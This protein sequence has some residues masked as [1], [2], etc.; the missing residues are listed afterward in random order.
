MSELKHYGTPRRSGRYPWGSG[1][2]PYQR[3]SDFLSIYNEYRRQGLSE[4]EIA[5]KMDI[6][7]SQLR[8][9]KT[10]SNNAVRAGDV[11]RAIR[12]KDKG[13]SNTEIGR[14][15]NKNES[16]I[17][18]LLD[19]TLQARSNEV[20]NM[21]NLLK[22]SIKEN[23][24]IDVGLGVERHLDISRTKL[25]TSIEMLKEE[26]YEIYYLK[27]DQA[28]TGKP[29]SLM[30]LA[31]P[32]IKWEEVNANK[33]NL[34][35]P[36][37]NIPKEV[38]EK[39]KAS[40]DLGPI[41]DISSNRV[42]IRYREDGGIDKDGL[43][44]LRR[45]VDDLSLGNSNYAQV[46][47]SVDGTHFLKGMSVYSDK[48]PEGYDIV[49]NTNKYKNTPKEEVFKKLK[50]DPDYPFGA[51]ITKRS[52]ALNIVNEEGA[53]GEWSKTL[54]SQ[55][56]SKQNKTLAK[57]QLDLAFKIKQEEYD[58]I[59]SLTN[60]TVKQ[61][62]LKSFADDCDASAVHLKAAA[63]PRQ[64]WHAIL[65]FPEMK[66]NEIYAPN[67]RN[68]ERVVLIR[69]PHGGTFE[70]P[71]LTVNNKQSIVKKVLGMAKDAVGINPKVA[72]QL[73]GAD[74]DGDT[75]LVIPTRGN[76]IKTS[77]PLKGLQNF[78][79]KESYAAYEGMPKMKPVTK[80]KEMGII[81]NLIT[82]M[83]IQGATPSELARAVRHSMVI[84][85]AEKHNLNYRQSAKD[86]GI[87]ALKA[88]YQSK[89]GK[90]GGASTLLSRAK[91]TLR[92]DPRKDKYRID[93]KTG[94]KIWV[95]EEEE[96]YIN[97]KGKLVKKT[98]STTQM[99]E[100]ENAFTLSSGTN[101]EAIYATY[102]NKLKALG[103][104]SRKDYINTKGLEY[105]PSARKTYSKEVSSLDAKLN[106]ALKNA[107]LERK[108]Q[109]IADAKVK[110]SRAA[111]PEMD[112][113]TL[114]KIK[115]QAI[116]SARKQV[117]AKKVT[118]DIS[119]I[120][121]EAIQ[122]GAISNNKLSKILDNTNN[123]LIKQLAT[124]RSSSSLSSAK[125]ARAKAMVTS[126]YTQAEIADAIGV[127]VSTLSKAINE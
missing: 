12:L 122:A 6:N 46:R 114:K 97:K 54:S 103:N 72:E 60:P 4:V 43:I 11:A 26:G 87:D 93:P 88:K 105:S 111:D 2:D 36:L 55:I 112:R 117:G 58:E 116:S 5:K 119:P 95:Q 8:A 42:F 107:P 22:D 15:M 28:G 73:S 99:Y 63:L 83:T 31:A 39:N 80:Q 1:E 90:V 96:S 115:G 106:L 13:Y 102:A 21:A 32:G 24:Y 69:H 104:Q 94:K 3:G 66:E 40:L 65:P 78:D 29:T 127:P 109:L 56:L 120:E 35:M 18:A 47:I 110:A 51:T 59:M 86:N 30:A 34:N 7:T 14:L 71:E 20:S 118:V 126:G 74:F 70:I 61:K 79:P 101:I 16:S 27:V 10:I 41:K 91:S 77:S 33:A 38:L 53:W 23:K 37:N 64:G 48:M 25:K 52:G 45:G 92:I 17:R 67:Y 50:D 82:D 123:D 108:A 19:P 84:I 124:P 68:G 125:I 62:L 49:Y 9:R 100:T 89:D 75:V 44:E 81:S 113:A 76:K 57:Q 121:W 98:I 85:D